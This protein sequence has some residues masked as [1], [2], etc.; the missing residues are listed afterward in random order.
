LPQLLEWRNDYAIWQWTRQNDFLNEVEHADWFERQAKDASLRMYKLVL[1]AGGKTITV[2]V[3]GLTSVCYRNS[4]AEFSLYVSPAFHKK[5]IGRHALTLLFT[6]GFTNLG[7]NV[8]WGE[9]FEGNPAAKLFEN[10][11]MVK[12]GT[13]R[14]F[15]WKNGKYID[16]H[17]YSITKG[18]WHVRR[19]NGPDLP[20]LSSDNGADGVVESSNGGLLF[21]KK[22][23]R[24][25]RRARTR[26]K[27][28]ADAENT[29]AQ[30]Q[31]AETNGQG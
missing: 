17:L 14:Q 6:H 22:D 28:V 8:I 5:G 2:G 16:A 21:H 24:P 20:G 10:L 11:G 7:L 13:R 25:I 9:T 26:A 27:K 18:E 12:E 31:Q 23:R 30:G 1:K 15:Y 3:C 19:D 4:R 29:S